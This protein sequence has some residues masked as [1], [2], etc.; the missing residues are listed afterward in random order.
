M[1]SGGGR[2]QRRGDVPGPQGSRGPGRPG[3]Q[4]LASGS[5]AEPVVGRVSERPRQAGRGAWPGRGE[6]RHW[7]RP[8]G[9]GIAPQNLDRP[10]EVSGTGLGG[11]VASDSCAEPQQP[12]QQPRAHQKWG[13]ASEAPEPDLRAQALWAGLWKDSPCSA[14]P[15]ARARH[16]E[17]AQWPEPCYRL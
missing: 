6:C 5:G 14:A 13:P 9:N 2:L 7:P 16:P 17:K 11:A 4:G 10:Q 15:R 8:G 1:P 3:N 12:E